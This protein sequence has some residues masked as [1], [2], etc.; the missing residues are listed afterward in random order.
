MKKYLVRVTI[1]ALL[2]GVLVFGMHRYF[3]Q[4]VSGWAWASILFYYG[5]NLLVHFVSQTALNGSQQSFIRFVYGTT[6]MRFIFSIFFIVIYLIINDVM[7][8]YVIGTFLFS[9]L[10][11]TTFEL[12]YLV[13]KLRTEK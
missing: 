6:G 12:H 1:L 13:T 7:S 9:Y 11:F 4:E 3:E 8:K 2:A 5:L 10:L